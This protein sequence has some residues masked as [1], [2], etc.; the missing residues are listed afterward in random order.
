MEVQDQVVNV[1]GGRSLLLVSD[2]WLEVWPSLEPWSCRAAAKNQA[3]GAIAVSDRSQG[4]L[5]CLSRVPVIAYSMNQQ[6]C[7]SQRRCHQYYSCTMLKV[8]GSQ[9]CKSTGSHMLVE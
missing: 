5:S 6:L 3:W 9:P 8:L 7:F 2:Q 1:I 4:P